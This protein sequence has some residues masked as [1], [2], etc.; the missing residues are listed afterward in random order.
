MNLIE[1]RTLALAGILQA[2]KQ[3]QN[4]ARH[5][6]VDQ[7]DFEPSVKSILV[8]DAVST[9]AVYG[10]VDGVRSGLAMI[11]GGILRSPQAL[12]VEVLRY[13]MSILH[14]QSQLFNDQAK[15]TSFGQAVERLSAYSGEEL[16]D[17]CSEVYQ[18]HISS[19][20]PQIIVQGE[21]NHLQRADVPPQVRSLLLAALRSAVLWQQK[22][23]SRFKLLWQRTRM[24]NAATQLLR[25]GPTH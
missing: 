6:R 16:I 2:C 15:F 25:Q 1:E 9:A 5:G 23:G 4:L 17:A 11:Q 22:Q 20:R 3:V 19:M 13:L 21:E 10:G 18:Q 24:Q 8:L 7:L 12:D 14:L